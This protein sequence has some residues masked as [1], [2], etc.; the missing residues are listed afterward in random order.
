MPP[1]SFGG[2]PGSLRL[3]TESVTRPGA[4][5]LCLAFICYVGQ[6][7]S[8][9]TWLPTFAVDERGASAGTAALITAAFVAINIPGNQLG[10]WLLK[11]GVPRVAVLAGGALAM[12]IGSLGLLTAAAPD[13]LR[14]ASALAFSLLGGVIPAAVFAGTTVHAKSP[15]HI[16]TMNGMLMQS[17][18]LS[19]FVLPILFAWLASRSGGWSASLGTMLGLAAAG[20]VAAFV[21]GRS[22]RRPR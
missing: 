9:M 10:G 3:L 21:V 22:E 17:S 14:L 13:A 16:G 6:W 2:N 1:A 11:R 18:H 19:Q 5:A 8:V 12:G 15:E 7:S 4:L 20:A